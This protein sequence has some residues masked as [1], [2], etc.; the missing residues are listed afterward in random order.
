LALL[1]WLEPDSSDDNEPDLLTT[2][3]AGKL[4]V[5]LSE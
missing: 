5:L 4:A 2:Q 1:P 3:A